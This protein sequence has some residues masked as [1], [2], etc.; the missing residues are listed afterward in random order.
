[1]KL[2]SVAQK[3]LAAS[4]LAFNREKKKKKKGFKTCMEKRKAITRASDDDN[5]SDTRDKVL[6]LT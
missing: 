6:N 2:F 5:R 1:M 4:L 3:Q